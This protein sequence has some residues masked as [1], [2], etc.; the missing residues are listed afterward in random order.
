MPATGGNTGWRADALEVE[1][2]IVRD[3]D[4]LVLARGR[5]A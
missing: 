1:G 4:R 5:E 2:A 3:A